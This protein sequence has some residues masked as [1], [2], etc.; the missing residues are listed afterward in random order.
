MHRTYGEGNEGEGRW[1]RG[2]N[3]REKKMLLLIRRN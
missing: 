2:K 3:K 1:Q